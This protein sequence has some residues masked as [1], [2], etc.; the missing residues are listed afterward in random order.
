M[1][2]LKSDQRCSLR[3]TGAGGLR[4]NVGDEVEGGEVSLFVAMESVCSSVD[5]RNFGVMRD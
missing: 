3:H 5:P 1:W 2:S 4:G